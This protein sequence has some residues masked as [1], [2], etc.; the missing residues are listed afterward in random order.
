ME[1]TEE[2]MGE[3]AFEIQPI[4]SEG[5]RFLHK[6]TLALADI[7]QTGM[8]VDLDYCRRQF[9]RLGKRMDHSLQKLDD[10]EFGALWRKVHRRNTKLGADSQ[11][12]TILYD[13][14]GLNPP[15]TTDTGKGQ[16][17]AEALDA[18]IPEIPELQ[19]VL[20]YK[21]WKKARDTYIKGI[22][23]ET[24]EDGLLRPF[25]HLHTVQ[26]YRGSSSDPNFQN[27]PVRDP[28]IGK[29]VRSAFIPRP[30]R[31][32]LEVDYSGIEVRIAAC[33]HLDPTMLEYI[34]DPK[35]DMHRDTAMELFFLK[36]R[37]VMKPV[38]HAAKNKFVFPEF[39]GDY[40]ASCA[41]ALWNEI[42]VSNLETA[43][44]VPLREHLASKGVIDYGAFE[45][46]VKGVENGFWNVRFPVYTQWKEDWYKAYELRGF[47]DTFT[48][49]R[50]S[51]F[52]QKNQVINYPVQGAAFHCLLW[53]LTELHREMKE[54]NMK[55]VIIGQIHDSIVLD[56]VE[57][58]IPLLSKLIVDITTVRLR[59][60]WDWI[61]TPLE[62][63]ADLAPVDGSWHEK[64]SFKLA[65]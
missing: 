9:K 19:Y 15:S 5:Y 24:N 14:L 36:L 31:R 55:S 28:A 47:F 65:A 39:Y 54:R 16:V 11:L 25:F 61:V 49:F 50:C 1:P 12:A 7:E 43:D 48:G 64:E 45:K 33:Y 2:T 6:A 22:I 34:N 42:A 17:N 23:R 62:V 30:G 56:V 32:I 51:G 26:T 4:T 13:E 8:R 53:S 38:R 58:E 44:G 46:H 21:K 10:S 59:K 52:M 41:R 37:Q 29:L 60:H 3:A 18:F 35:S 63:E 57:E 20:D 40:Y 27:I